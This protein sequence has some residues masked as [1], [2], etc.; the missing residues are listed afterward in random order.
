IDQETGAVL[1]SP[2]FQWEMVDLLSQLQSKFTYPMLIH[3][4]T[5][6]MA[7]GQKWFGFGQGEVKSFAC[8][9]LGHGIGAALYLDGHVYHGGSGSAGELGHTTVKRDGPVCV[10]GNRG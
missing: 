7:I 2:D 8:I 4:V 10:C 5:R 6:A 1:I 3:N 9:N